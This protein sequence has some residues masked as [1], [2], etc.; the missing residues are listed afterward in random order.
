M[1]VWVEDSYSSRGVNGS[2]IKVKMIIDWRVLAAHCFPFYNGEAFPTVNVGRA[3]EW[4][5]SVNENLTGSLL[6]KTSSRSSS[7][8][9]SDRQDNIDLT[10]E[11]IWD[12]SALVSSWNDAYEEYQVSPSR[13][14][15]YIVL[16]IVSTSLLYLTNRTGGYLRNTTV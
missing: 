5:P 7:N 15:L 14:P 16:T 6:L 13:Y 1:G 3:C 2:G 11:E 9:T 8:M 4:L 12:D 10:H